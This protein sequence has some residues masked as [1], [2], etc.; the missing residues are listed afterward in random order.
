MNSVTVYTADGQAV[1]L[2]RD[3]PQQPAT[4]QPQT[5]PSVTDILSMT[6]A[7]ERVTVTLTVDRTHPHQQHRNVIGADEYGQNVY[8]PDTSKLIVISVLVIAALMLFIKII[9]IIATH[10]TEFAA[11]IVALICLAGAVLLLR[12]KRQ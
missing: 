1:T 12:G 3:Q 11:G 6:P 8:A 4:A 2:Y 10:P 9:E 7:G 5:L